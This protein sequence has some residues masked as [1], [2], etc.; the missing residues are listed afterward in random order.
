MGLGGGGRG[1][2][3]NVGRSRGG[4]GTG[5]AP[6]N[7]SLSPPAPPPTPPC[8][9]NAPRPKHCEGAAAAGRPPPPPS[10]PRPPSPCRPSPPSFPP[11]QIPAVA[12]AE[13]AVLGKLRWAAQELP[14][15]PTA[16][17]SAQLCAL[18]RSCAE[19]LKALRGLGVPPPVPPAPQTGTPPP[20]PP[21]SGS[22]P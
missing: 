6:P 2:T 15:N 18:I 7:S 11:S 9:P 1:V 17:G 22:F 4:P 8:H 21:D 12:E 14:A 20:P 13:A 5:T 10:S 16:E 19:A 3:G